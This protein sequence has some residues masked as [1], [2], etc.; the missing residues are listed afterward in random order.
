MNRGLAMLEGFARPRAGRVAHRIAAV[1]VLGCLLASGAV[2]AQEESPLEPAPASPASAAT[3]GPA[4]VPAPP[5]AALAPPPPAPANPA[6]DVSSP[7]PEP[8]KPSLFRRWWFWTAV[9]AAVG[10]TVA[11]V[12]I[13]SRGHAPPTT[14]LG[15]QEF[16]P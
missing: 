6:L 16:Q 9:G 2:R 5:P 10:A 15:N 4:P 8:A 7:A 14:D 3:P 13:S 1:L 12:V 11:I